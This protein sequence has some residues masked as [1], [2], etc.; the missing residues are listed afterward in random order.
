MT[1]QV[2]GRDSGVILRQPRPDEL[3]RVAHLFRNTRLRAG[4]NF[5]VAEKTWPMARFV[6]AAM[7]WSEGAVGRVQIAS[8]PGLTET[9]AISSLISSVSEAVRATG[10]EAVHYAD[11]VSDGRVLLEILQDQGFERLRSERSFEL[12]YRDAWTRV[13]RLHEKHVK[14]VPPTWRTERIEAH[15][16]EV[17]LELIAP[18]RL[19]P[20]E[21]VRQHWQSA[22]AA[23][24]DLETSCILFDLDRPFG[25]FLTRR[26]L[27]VLFV[28]VQVVQ[29]PNPRLRSL[30]DLCMLHH[31]A[32]LVPPGG[33]VQWI[34]FRSGQ[35]E[36]RQTANL[37]LRMGGR[38]LPRMHVLGKR[39]KS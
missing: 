7:W 21:E 14:K 37:A 29:E 20:P 4:S 32:T 17:I 36:H 1:N 12:A 26:L 22:G 2:F 38:E 10:L 24:F 16:P 15:R 19:L 11:L 8:L 3:V 35:T 28:D 9:G 23:G 6:A 27:D 13:I 25:A 18:H 31:G 5:L 39:L 33:A 34:R 30:A